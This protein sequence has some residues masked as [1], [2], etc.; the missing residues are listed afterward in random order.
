MLISELRSSNIEPLFSPEH[1]L[2]RGGTGKFESLVRGTR[3]SACSEKAHT[4]TRKREPMSGSQAIPR[5]IRVS[6]SPRTP[7]SMRPT[8]ESLSS[9][10]TNTGTILPPDSRSGVSAWES[11]LEESSSNKEAF[12]VDVAAA[13]FLFADVNCRLVIRTNTVASPRRTAQLFKSTF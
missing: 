2:G 12:T 8:I 5:C 10:A 9:I 4:A 3:V 13:V 7:L 11:P 1:V 6:I